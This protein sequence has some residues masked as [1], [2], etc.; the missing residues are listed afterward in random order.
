[1]S[2]A[3]GGPGWWQAS[4][5]KWYSPEQAPAPTVAPP[6]PPAS[7]KDARDQARAAKAYAK[8]T[9]PWYRKKR[10]WALA[11]IVLLIVIIAVSVSNSAS[12]KHTINYSVTGSGTANDITYDTLQEGN[13]QNGEAQVTN[14]ALPWSKTIQASG[15]VTAFTLSATVGSGGGSVTC[16]ITEDGKVVNTNT[17]TGAFATATCNH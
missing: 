5:G 15:L 8:A 11:I 16:T 6:P 1:M 9:R 7:P 4:D 10:W 3:S 12:T 14:V 2:D 13:G 17:A